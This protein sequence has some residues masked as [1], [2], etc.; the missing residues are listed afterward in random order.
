MLKRSIVVSGALHVAVI[1]A[2]TVAW[3]GAVDLSD[4][5]PPTVPV[6]LV[7]VA[8]VTN[9]APTV[10]E[11]KKAETQPEQPA[12]PQPQA[13]A[14]PPPEAE[15]APP[16]PEKAP[17]PKPKEAPKEAEQNAPPPP[18]PALP[19]RK[20]QPES[21]SKFDVDSVL[22]LLDKRAPKAAAPPANAKQAEQTVKGIGA[23]DA[24]TMDIKDALL[25]QIRMCWN[26][27]VGAPNPEQLIVQVRVFL[28]QDGH[29]AQLPQIEPASRAAAAANPYMRAAA[30]AAT[31]AVN[32][33]APY[34]YLP[35]EKYDSWREIVM[36]FDPSKMVGR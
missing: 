33:C 2:A 28:T 12:P 31:R 19:R 10:V 32:S 14:P 6:D 5:T 7:T 18:K 22:A 24:L 20:P 23:Q 3:R 15:V 13:A 9:I 11:T 21:Q 25:A 8:D 26:V 17:I 1:L 4:D 27:P 34:K 36:T 29:L 16:D 35:V 30:D